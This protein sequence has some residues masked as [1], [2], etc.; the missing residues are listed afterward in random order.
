MDATKKRGLAINTILSLGPQDLVIY[1]GGSANEGTGDGGAGVAI[2]TGPPDAPQI[3]Q[4]MS[5]AAGPL[6]SSMDAECTALL[7][8]ARW[9]RR[10]TSSHRSVLLCTDSRSALDESRHSKKMNMFILIVS[11]PLVLLSESASRRVLA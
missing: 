7:K 8:A 3:L 4:S 11:T 9:L 1:M 5:F 10:N 2:T 6:C